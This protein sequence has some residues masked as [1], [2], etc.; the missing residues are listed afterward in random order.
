MAL[1]PQPLEA[2]TLNSKVLL[3]G[4]LQRHD[5]SNGTR[6]KTSHPKIPSSQADRIRSRGYSTL[7]DRVTGMTL[8][9]RLEG[10]ED[11]TKHKLIRKAIYLVS[12]LCFGTISM[13][14]AALMYNNQAAH[15]TFALCILSASAWNG[16]GFYGE[17]L[18]PQHPLPIAPW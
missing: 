7:F 5:S 10:I 17:D 4:A 16:A 12:H 6:P 8:G 18:L 9:K 3:P 14:L 2:L 11:S 1:D 15:F 13:F